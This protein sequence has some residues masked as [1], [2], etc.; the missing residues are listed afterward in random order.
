MTLGGTDKRI[1]VDGSIADDRVYLENID[2][3]NEL[4]MI[5]ENAGASG[6]Y[7]EGIIDEVRISG[8]ERSPAWLSLS[9]ASIRDQ[10]VVL[11]GPLDACTEL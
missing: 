1:F 3:T 8:N 5:G 11:Y 10:G 2:E 6:R 9:N 4:V 7:F